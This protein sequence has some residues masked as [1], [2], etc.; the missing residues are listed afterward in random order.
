MSRDDIKG[1]G[2]QASSAAEAAVALPAPEAA[3]LPLA[4]LL[5]LVDEAATAVACFDTKPEPEV[6]KAAEGLS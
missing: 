1:G 4:E 2:L 3:L 6:P 5:P